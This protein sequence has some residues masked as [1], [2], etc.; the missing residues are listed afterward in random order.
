MLFPGQTS[1]LLLSAMT[2]ADFAAVTAPAVEV[3]LV[4]RA[5]LGQL[6][7]P[8]ENIW[9]PLSGIVSIIATDME[10]NQAEI[11][12]VGADGVVDIAGLL[13]DRIGTARLLVQAPGRALQ[14]PVEKLRAAAEASTSLLRILLVYVHALHLQLGGSALAFARYTIEQ[15]LARWLLM[16][17]DRGNPNELPMTHETIA[18]MLGV[19]RAGVTVALNR[20]ADTGA[21]ATA[22]GRVAVRDRDQLL[23][24]AG[25]GYGEPEA[26]YKRLIGRSLPSTRR[27][28]LEHA[29]RFA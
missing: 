18:I 19:R 27:P 21:I 1:N 10:D 12:L 16:A 28:A 5:E 6:G 26:A 11:G 23:A 14:V 7:Q 25:P 15:R 17:A 22:R 13:G 24:I 29:L 3:E 9:F 8:I 4:H 20:L 2:Q